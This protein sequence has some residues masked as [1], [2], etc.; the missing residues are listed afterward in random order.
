MQYTLLTDS[1]MQYIATFAAGITENQFLD[2]KLLMEFLSSEPN[3]TTKVTLDS[4][5]AL[6]PLA[7]V[8]TYFTV[9]I[10]LLVLFGF[11]LKKNRF[12]NRIKDWSLQA[13]ILF[14][15]PL[16]PVTA[17]GFILSV[18]GIAQLEQGQYK[19]FNGYFIAIIIMQLVSEL[20]ILDFVKGDLRI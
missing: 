3:L 20:S 4:T 1:R 15:Y 19:K 2:K 16:L 17:F 6:R 5:S 8:I 10:E 13:F 12:F 9:G 14:L 7:L 18:L 11:A